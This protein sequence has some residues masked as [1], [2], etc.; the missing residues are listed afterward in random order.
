MRGCHYHG[1]EC[2]SVHFCDMYCCH[3]FRNTVYVDVLGLQMIY[4]DAF[5]MSGNTAALPSF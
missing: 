2:Q 1:V 4:Y 3:L 5:T